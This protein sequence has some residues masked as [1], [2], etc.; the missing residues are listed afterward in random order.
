MTDR[1]AYGDVPPVAVSDDIGAI[2]FEMLQDCGRIVAHLRHGQRPVDVGRVAMAL[3]L[4]RNHLPGFREFGQDRAERCIDRRKRA[5]DQQHRLTRAV[6][7]VIDFQRPRLGI[8]ASHRRRSA[9]EASTLLVD[10]C[11]P[12]AESSN[13]AAQAFANVRITCMNFSG[14]ATQQGNRE[15]AASVRPRC[16]NC[17]M[18]DGWPI[19]RHE[20]IP[21]KRSGLCLAA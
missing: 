19:R 13:S 7:L 20:R 21:P 15:L 11:A 4:H 9:A 5:R 6:D 12:Q 18:P 2:D 8:A 17:K 16:P 1:Q 10:G 3:A 14:P